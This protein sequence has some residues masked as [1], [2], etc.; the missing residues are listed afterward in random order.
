MVFN[1]IV[2]D[3]YYY[4]WSSTLQGRENKVSVDKYKSSIHNEMKL[5]FVKLSK[6]HF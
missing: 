2:I 3:G 1:N 6:F 4:L 5:N